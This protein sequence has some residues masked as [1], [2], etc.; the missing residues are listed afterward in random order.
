[1]LHC[2]LYEVVVGGAHEPQVL[3]HHPVV[4]PATLPNVPVHPPAEPDV[5][6][7]GH[8]Y[9]HPHELANRRV[10]E[11]EDALEQNEVGVGQL[12]FALPLVGLEVV[13]W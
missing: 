2:R 4:C 9:P 11:C 6:V 3:F 5:V 13:D 8:E 10:V 7:A 1:M 12:Y